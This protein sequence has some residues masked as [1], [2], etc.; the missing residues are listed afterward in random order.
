MPPQV[1]SANQMGNP[2][3][4]NMPAR[5]L[6][7]DKYLVPHRPFLVGQPTGTQV[8]QKPQDPL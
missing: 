1:E 7:N 3:P 5:Q 2:T 4:Q 8:T 6:M